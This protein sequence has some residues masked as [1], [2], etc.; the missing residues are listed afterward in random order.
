M[1][2]FKENS[3]DIVKLLLNQIGIAIF[4]LAV[5]VAPSADEGSFFS[6]FAIYL[7]ILAIVFYFSLIY[8]TAWDFGIKDKMRNESGKIELIKNKGLKLGFCAN[9]PNFILSGLAIIFMLCYFASANEVLYS[10]FFTF[11]LFI[12]FTSAMFLGLLQAVFS[13]LK[14]KNDL[15]YL[16][17]TVGYFI[18]PVFTMLVT[19][20][21]YE[22]GRRD[23]RIFGFISSNKNNNNLE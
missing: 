16:W 11:N 22:L 6:K 10:L 1:K 19:H 5:Y 9:I 12:R 3:Y 20:L 14:E 7:S 18:V 8:I 2:F 13:F 15:Y 21:G 23:I 4:S 17:Q